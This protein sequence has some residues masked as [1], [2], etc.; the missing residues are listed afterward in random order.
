MKIERSA[1]PEV[2]L[3]LPDLFQENLS[4]SSYPKLRGIPTLQ[5]NS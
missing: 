3:L 4:G 1:A 2:M 5:L